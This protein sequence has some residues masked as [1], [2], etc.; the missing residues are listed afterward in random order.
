[1]KCKTI[2]NLNS[3]KLFKSL[4]DK[5]KN[6]CF[7]YSH[8]KNGFEKFL[9]INPVDK[10][11]YKSSKKT[12]F[13]KPLKKF[14]EKQSQKHRK[15]IGYISYDIGY[16]LHNIKKTAKD[17]LLLPDIYFLAF[18]NFITFSKSDAKIHYNNE[19]FLKKITSL[20]TSKASVLINKSFAKQNTILNSNQKKFHKTNIKSENFKP[21][22]TIKTYNNAYKKIKDHILEGDIYQINLTHRLKAKTSL[23][24]RELFIK[25]LNSNKVDH[26]AYIEGE[27][28]EVLSASPERFIKI[29]N[30]KIETCPIKGTRPRGKTLKEDE[31]FRKE[32]LKNEKE[33]AEL[34]MITDLLRND[35]GKICKIGT[36]KVK[37][38]RLLSKCDTVWHTYSRITGKLADSTHSIEALIS[39]IPGGSITG[40]PKKRAMEIIDE[41]EPT[42]RS[43]YTGAI[44]IIHENGDMDMNIAIR[45]II[46]KDT[47]LYLQVGG[48]IVF[49]ST[50]AQ[51]YEETFHKAQS[52]MK[53]L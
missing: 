53:I 43:V 35:L 40:C 15:I 31:K 29:T 3:L 5:E 52:F 16:E 4:S 25:I 48:G 27:G 51:E 39:M 34:N 32:L 2:K 6:V 45:T 8:K 30:R 50:N 9:G 26:L 1:M 18:E 21:E 42:T 24:P 12:D 10:F 38:H 44:G 37:E 20:D 23:P 36:V 28:F 47:A 17:D 33:A 11:I 46:K 41:L 22:M 19:K 7:L 14:I 49:D 13:M